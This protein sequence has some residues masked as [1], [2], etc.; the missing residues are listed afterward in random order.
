MVTI[1]IFL[2]SSDELSEER[3][4]ISNLIENLNYR[5]EPRG[6]RL[7]LI[8]WE[9]LD[10][11]MGNIRKQEEYNRILK[12]CDICMVLFWK[13]IGRFT[14]EELDVA[15]HEQKVGRKPQKI[16]IFFKK[17]SDI[18]SEL[19]EFKKVIESSYGHFYNTFETVE[20]LQ[21]DFLLQLELFQNSFH[22]G[23]SME[24]IDSKIKIDGIEFVDASQ[25]PFCSNNMEYKELI[26]EI[27]ELNEILI[28]APVNI[29][30]QARLEKLLS[31]KHTMESSLLDTA[32]EISKLNEESSNGRLKTAIE[33]F[34]NGDCKGANAILSRDLIQAEMLHNIK[35]LELGK[36]ILENSKISIHRNVEELYLKIKTL[37]SL[38]KEASSEEIY[39]IYQQIV[40]VIYD[41]LN[42]RQ[43]IHIVKGLLDYLVETKRHSELGREITNLFEKIDIYSL[44]L[45]YKIAIL[46]I[47]AYYLIDKEKYDDAEVALHDILKYHESLS[48][49]QLAEIYDNLAQIHVHT[50]EFD[51]AKSEYQKAI[52]FSNLSS[53]LIDVISSTTNF[54]FL[55]SHVGEQE[56]AIQLLNW[57]EERLKTITDDSKEFFL[58]QGRLFNTRGI[59]FTAQGLKEKA[60]EA[61]LNAQSYFKKAYEKSAHSIAPHLANCLMNLGEAYCS[62]LKY[63]SAMKYLNESFKLYNLLEE[64][65]PGFYINDVALCIANIASCFESQDKYQD[66]TLYYLKAKE[67]YE[68]LVDN[69]SGSDNLALAVVYNN[70]AYCYAKANESQMA[71]DFYQKCV[72]LCN[73]YN[74]GIFDKIRSVANDNI[75]KLIQ[76]V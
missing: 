59:V 28:E 53:P 6:I 33:L 51:K 67:L 12:E 14:K 39:S 45:N 64:A 46:N 9:F 38:D 5:F 11:S 20:K 17:T 1:K 42:V 52:A 24:L 61:F 70:L 13:K 69:H 31:K 63:E 58:E 34:N 62:V 48:N 68:S 75:T 27:S 35:N 15:Y 44:D 56:S 23:F 19:T 10:A 73:K 3:V 26:E 65:E 54:A 16:Y 29:K 30:L 2:A 66:A 57:T 21:L 72:D 49:E 8:K 71:K 37:E 55:M 25:I 22:K 76:S 7:Q 36:S 47:K 18:T 41:Y 60:L 50:R 43:Y 74:D 32:R 40:V 4:H